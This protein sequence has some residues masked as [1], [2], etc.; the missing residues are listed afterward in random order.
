MAGSVLFEGEKGWGERANEVL[1]NVIRTP[2]IVRLFF[3]GICLLKTALLEH[4]LSRETL[5][6]AHFSCLLPCAGKERRAGC[7]CAHGKYFQNQILF[8]HAWLIWSHSVWFCC[9]GCFLLYFV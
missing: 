5:P 3:P 6:Q 1:K 2:K 9:S 8:K 4:G 7:F